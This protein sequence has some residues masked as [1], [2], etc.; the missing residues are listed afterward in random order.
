MRKTNLC[1]TMLMFAVVLM[2]APVNQQKTEQIANFFFHEH[3]GKGDLQFVHNTIYSHLHFYI[4]ENGKGFVI[5]AADDCVLPVLGY[6][7]S[8]KLDLNNMGPNTKL[9]FDEYEKQIEWNIKNEYKASSE[10]TEMWKHLEK[11]LPE[12]QQAPAKVNTYNTAN[13]LTS[14]WGQSPYYNSQCPYDSNEGKRTIT[15]CVATAMG[16]IMRYWGYPVRGT[17]SKTY[18]DSNYGTQSADFADTVFNYAIMPNEL[19]GSTTSAEVNAV[20]LLLRRCGISVGMSYGVNE[21]SAPMIGDGSYG[22]SSSE[23]AYKEFFKFMHTLHRVAL[24]DYS[25]AEWIDLMKNEIDSGRPVQ[26]SAWDEYSGGGHCFICSGYDNTGKLYFNWGWGGYCDGNYQIGQLNPGGSK[27]NI[28]NMAIVGIVPD[29]TGATTTKVTIT[30]D[31]IATGTATGSGTYTSYVDVVTMNAKPKPGYLFKN[32]ENGN[33]YAHY[34][35]VANGDSVHHTAYF[36]KIEGDTVGLC[37]DSNLDYWG[38]SDNRK[39]FWAICLD[40]NAIGLYKKLTSVN[41]YI[42]VSGKYMIHIFQGNTISKAN[43]LH[44]DT[45]SI[46]SKQKFSW[47]NIPLSKSIKINNNKKLWIVLETTC[48]GYPMTVSTYRGTIEGSYASNNLYSG[49]YNYVTNY[50]KYFTFQIRGVF[51]DDPS[52]SGV[53]CVAA[54]E[55]MSIYTD[56]ES[57][58]I[59]D[60]DGKMIMVYDATGKMVAN[61]QSYSNRESITVPTGIYIVS[62]DRKAHKVVVR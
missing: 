38:S 2:A 59:E 55:G 23:N 11:M 45:V 20:A 50:K 18:Y 56:R 57:I 42:S 54:D 19:T 51:E 60:A 22:F 10:V 35:F 37:Y 46:Q 12:P 3:G 62:V 1:M 14:T 31:N 58:I 9:W 8:N 25:D 44:S 27:Y 39:R 5:M 28:R 21:S 61:R 47:V 15:G 4:S 29:T 34:Q 6:S 26:Y 41:S 30:S 33:T 32:W 48:A 43:L 13:L 52:A 17:G 36:E 24:E 49:W 7:A 40:S 53:E 16:Q